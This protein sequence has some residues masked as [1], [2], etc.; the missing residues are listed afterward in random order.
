MDELANNNLAPVFIGGGMTHLL[1]PTD[2]S[3]K[4]TVQ[5]HKE[6]VQK[7]KE[8]AEQMRVERAEQIRVERQMMK[9]RAEQFWKEMEVVRPL[10]VVDPFTP[11]LQ[12]NQDEVPVWFSSQTEEETDLKQAEEKTRDGHEHEGGEEHTEAAQTQTEK[13][14]EE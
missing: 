12:M 2:T 1:Q 10:C 14:K 11:I 5:K 9:E 8:R 13:K 6:K 7:F 4:E 3:H